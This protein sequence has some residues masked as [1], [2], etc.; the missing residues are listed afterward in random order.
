[1][2]RAR[3]TVDD[4]VPAVRALAGKCDAPGG[5]DDDRA[6][7]VPPVARVAVG[8]DHPLRADA[9]GK[10]DVRACDGDGPAGNAAIGRMPMPVDHDE[11][12]P[13]VGDDL[14]ALPAICRVTRPDD[15]GPA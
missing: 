10:G 9:R 15:G 7:A 5:S 4:N 6:D 13:A 1:M 14:D 2:W 8:D 11:L 3:N 12:E